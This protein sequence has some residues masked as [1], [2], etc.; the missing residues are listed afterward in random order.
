M[1]PEIQCSRCGKRHY[2]GLYLNRNGVTNLAH[3]GKSY[4]SALYCPKCAKEI[5]RFNENYESN[6]IAILQWINARYEL[7]PKK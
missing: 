1:C 3:T 6:L 4:G 7:V 2:V 5:S